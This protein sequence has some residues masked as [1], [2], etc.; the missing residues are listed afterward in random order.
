MRNGLIGLLGILLCI[1]MGGLIWYN[2]KPKTTK[3]YFEKPGFKTDTIIHKIYVADTGKKATVIPPKIIYQYLEP[4]YQPIRY[5]HDLKHDTLWFQDS[6]GH[7]FSLSTYYL[8]HYIGQPK[9]VGARFTGAGISMDLW[10]T[11]GKLLT[12]VY[13][14]N[15]KDYDYFWNGT[16]IKIGK[17]H[18]N[19]IPKI[20]LSKFYTSCNM[21]LTHEV[22]IQTTLFSTDYS[23]NFKSIG[24]YGRGDIGYYIPNKTVETR[25]SFGIR[26]KLK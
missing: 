15:Y 18:T 21:Y 17:E 1:S 13:E 20:G 25:L 12:K 22:F 24:L 14:T 16:E 9:L 10:D 5:V 26:I 7:K 19:T 11:S 6:T 3:E 2:I 23:A 4:P 8:D